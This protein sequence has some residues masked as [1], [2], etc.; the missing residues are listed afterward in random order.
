MVLRFTTST[1]YKVPG[2]DGTAR[3]KAFERRVLTNLDFYKASA[4]RE[5][6]DLAVVNTTNTE[7]GY[8]HHTRVKIK[9]EAVP[10][11]VRRT[12]GPDALDY[13][14]EMNYTY[15]THKGTTENTLQSK[16]LKN[17]L[18]ARTKVTLEVGEEPNTVIDTVVWEVTCSMFMV[19]GA[20][21]KA[22][23]KDAR[24]R[25]PDG[26]V[27]IQAWMDGTYVPTAKTKREKSRRRG[28]SLSQGVAR[29]SAGL[30]RLSMQMAA[31][32]ST[33]G[34]TSQDESPPSDMEA[35]AE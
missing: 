16:T 32:R 18:K 26:E 15:A 5:G 6:A 25:M 4:E 22:I 7:D 34:T 8:T 24:S 13:D 33:V 11:L 10:M 2:D 20:L 12:L 23:M 35:A 17:K 27:F 9:P 28:S 30:R 21:E 29:V 3:L 31:P 1:T 14:E 19:G